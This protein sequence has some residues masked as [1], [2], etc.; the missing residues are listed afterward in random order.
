MGFAADITGTL[1]GLLPAQQAVL[2]GLAAP[3]AARP[4]RK[5]ER[6]ADPVTQAMTP[7]G[8]LLPIG[9]IREAVQECLQ[10]AIYDAAGSLY[11][12]MADDEIV[13]L[14][15][16]LMGRPGDRETVGRSLQEVVDS[17]AALA[18]KDGQPEDVVRAIGRFT[19]K[20]KNTT[21]QLT[22]LRRQAAEQ[23]NQGIRRVNEL[24][25]KI[26]ETNRQITLAGATGTARPQD[27]QTQLMHLQELAKVIDF[28]SFR[29]EDGSVAVFTKQGLALAK[30]EAVLLEPS[31]AGIK[32]DGIDIAAQLSAGS[33]HASLHNRDVT[34]PNVQSQLDTLAQTLQSRVNQ[35][36]NR[37]IGGADARAVYRGG[38]VFA[39]P[40]GVR[41]GLAGGD[42]EIL[43]LRPDD[44]VLAQATLTLAVKQ[45]R[46]AHGLPAAG[47]WP[48][49]QVVAALDQWLARQLAIAAPARLAEE[50]RLFIDLPADIRLALRDSRTLSLRSKLFASAD[51]P[52][53]A[54]AQLTLTDGLGNEFSTQPWRGGVALAPQDGLRQIAAKLDRLD[55]L[56][57]H[58]EANESG[59]ALIIAAK[60]GSDLYVEP[61]DGAA[62]LLSPVPAEDQAR[63]DVA[64]NVTA[65]T[66]VQQVSSRSFASPSLS[67]HLHGSLILRDLDGAMLAFQTPQPDWSLDKLTERLQ[68][69]SD[70]RLSAGIVKCGNQFALKIAMV[71]AD[72]RFVIEGLPQGWQTSPRFN[73]AAAG[74]DLTLSLAGTAL[75]GV[76]IA[77]GN[78]L[79]QIVE[80]IGD[81][82]W[83]QAGITAQLLRAGNAEILD[84]AHAGGLPLAFGG[85]AL[86]A[87]PGQLDLRYN[88]RDHLGLSAP[89]DQVVPGFANYFGLNDLFVADPFSAFDSKAAIGVFATTA[90][91]G[92]AAALAL[93]PGL[94]S[95]PAGLGA[96]VT[97]RQIS[98]LLC[99]ALN[100]AEAGDLP[101]GSYLPAQYADA[102]VRQVDNAARNNQVQLTFHRALLDRL[103]DEKNAEIDVNR[104]LGTLMALQQTYHDAT[105]IVAGL[106]RLNEQ[107]KLPVH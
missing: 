86:G 44:S 67:L 93:N 48:V 97:I 82:A 106:S 95:D 31:E 57:A 50:G 103:G 68:G 23:L 87:A 19:D 76:A 1:A 46:Q 74:G 84:I 62:A 70:P 92:T 38:R 22:E 4:V 45:Y 53:A 71:A 33:V 47:P 91:P 102:I 59:A 8:E 58:V 7:A 49:G 66:R 94:A 98:D 41:I 77:A 78:G 39:D 85:S 73:F 27:G 52:M 56:A 99:N 10:E 51:K 6:R 54:H 100:V 14:L 9:L 60:A 101:R 65:M 88:L 83:T 37:A 25:A 42:C 55:G 15:H 63:E 105:Q 61:D 3:P 30:D 43:L 69:A 89:P 21:R 32:A 26:A 34:L 29:R 13:Q 81:S 28:S 90:Q 79:A 80:R 107:L 16:K 5:V 40:A 36:S 24:L 64:V 18:A 17:F 20:L 2:S 75:G 72:D 96:A 11:A 35:L 104:R 12:L